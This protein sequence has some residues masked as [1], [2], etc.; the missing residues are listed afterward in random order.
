M[1]AGGTAESW[2]YGGE[3]NCLTHTDAIGGVTTF[4][5]G[6]FDLLD[7]RTGPDGTR[8]TFTHDMQL[9]LTGVTNPQGL[10]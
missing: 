4:E 6:D 5:Y 3:G 1:N 9:R 7:T 10:T 8:Y 2:T